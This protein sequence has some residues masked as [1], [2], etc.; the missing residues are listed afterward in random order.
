M[1]GPWLYRVGS[2]LAL[3]WTR[4]LLMRLRYRLLVGLIGLGYALGAM[5]YTGMIYVPHH[6]LNIPL[7]LYIEPTGPG[8]SWTY[9]AILAG[10]PY[11]QVDLPML[12]MVQMTLS[13]AGVGLG[14]SLSVLLVA[15]LLRQRRSAPLGTTTARSALGLT[16]AMIAFV[17]LGA[18]CSTSAAATAGI[19]LLAHSGGVGATALFANTWY[20][21]FVQVAVV[22]VALIAQE[23]LVRIYDV[24]SAATTANPTPPVGTATHTLQNP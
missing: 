21:G 13:A 7:F 5:L 4:S 14:M 8:A 1:P 20:L 15:R 16:P 3:Q 23:Q 18:C 19:G 22:Y 12:S 11:F 10:G 24:F 6:P 17:T 9:P 2:I